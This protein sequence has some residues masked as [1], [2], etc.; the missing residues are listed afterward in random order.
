[1]TTRRDAVRQA[2]ALSSVG[3]GAIH[4]ALGP[5]HMSEWAVLGIGFYVSGFLQLA[6]GARLVM[7][8]SRR[9]M[10]FGVF[11]SVLYVGVWL[12]S[13]TTGLPLGPQQWQAESSGRADLIC[14]ALE[15]VVALGALYLLRKP[16]AG[17]A[18]AGR[19]AV[20]GVLS[21]V[22]LTVLATTGVAVAAPSHEH[23]GRP[24]PLKAVLTGTDNNHNGA[25]DGNEA[26]FGCLLRHEHDH[27]K[28][29]SA[30]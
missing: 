16:A 6:W 23:S 4:V 8:E 29:Y 12:M 20:R 30:S 25:D 28:G 14:I 7:T 17:H 22:A 11:Q 9:L 1:M 21:A 2:L 24:C 27:H 26:Y 15:S 13:R 5:E 19:L 3:A 10:A 18:P